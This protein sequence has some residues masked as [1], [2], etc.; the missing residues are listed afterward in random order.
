MI[1]LDMGLVD[2]YTLLSENLKSIMV[3]MDFEPIF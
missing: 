3:V 2:F 1:S